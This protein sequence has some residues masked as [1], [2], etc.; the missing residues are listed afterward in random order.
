MQEIKDKRVEL[1]GNKSIYI[2]LLGM[3]WMSTTGFVYLTGKLKDMRR[4]TN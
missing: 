4:E 2:V 3:L 1:I